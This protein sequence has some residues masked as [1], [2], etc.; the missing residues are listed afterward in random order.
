MTVVPAIM[1]RPMLLGKSGAFS[2]C[3]G[4][5]DK[6]ATLAKH[7]ARNAYVNVEVIRLAGAIRM[8]SK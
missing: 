7:V 4:K 1:E 5:P 6:C 8:G 2:S 3:T